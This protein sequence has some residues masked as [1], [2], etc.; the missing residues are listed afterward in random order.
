MKKAGRGK[1]DVA[2]RAACIKAAVAE[3]D[4]LVVAGKGKEEV[5]SW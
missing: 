4:L 1:A 3:V 2:D 5:L